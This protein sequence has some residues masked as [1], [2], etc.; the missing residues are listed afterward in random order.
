MCMR[1]LGLRVCVRR[2][3]RTGAR[4]HKDK[5]GLL[6]KLFFVIEKDFGSYGWLFYA[7]EVALWIC[8]Y[9]GSFLYA[10]LTV[11]RFWFYFRLCK[12]LGSFLYAALTAQSG[13]KAPRSDRADP[14]VRGY[15]PPYTPAELLVRCVGKISLS[16]V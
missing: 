9:L 15:A 16:A 2:M 7:T 13:G 4:I 14:R 3:S 8:K 10:A 6:W 5:T 12:Y 11:R 1:V